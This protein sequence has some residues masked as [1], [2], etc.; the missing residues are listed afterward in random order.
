MKCWPLA[1]WSLIS[2]LW[3][4]DWMGVIVVPVL[5]VV[6]CCEAVSL[7]V[8]VTRIELDEAKVASFPICGPVN[9]VG[10]VRPRESE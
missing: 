8:F 6:D 9:A 2:D 7:S 5:G 1:F 4:D 3:V 10:K